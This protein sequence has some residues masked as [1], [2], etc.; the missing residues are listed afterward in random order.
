MDFLSSPL[1]WV[2]FVLTGLFSFVNLLGRYMQGRFSPHIEAYGGILMFIVLVLSF[3]FFGWEGGLGIFV[4][5]I[6]WG[7]VFVIIRHVIGLAE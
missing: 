7:I 2:F 4:S 3:I 5:W 1:W 6:I